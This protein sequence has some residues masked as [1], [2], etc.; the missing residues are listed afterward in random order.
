MVQRLSEALIE[1]SLCDAPLSW[2]A[3]PE[4]LHLA[5]VAEVP[6]PPTQARRL[7]FRHPLPLLR[8]ALQSRP[9]FRQAPKE[10]RTTGVLQL[11]EEILRT[12][13]LLLQG[14]CLK[15]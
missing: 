7:Q 1:L 2:P 11:Q 13:M 3:W 5:R 6:R 4:L 12:I 8:P 10:Q 14:R 15:E 9:H